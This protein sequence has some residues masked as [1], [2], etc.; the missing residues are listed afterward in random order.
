[1][2]KAC[3]EG[4]HEVGLLATPSILQ[5]RKQGQSGRKAHTGISGS[6]PYAKTNTC[7]TLGKQAL[8]NHSARNR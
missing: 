5:L 1:M 4:V 2:Q 7:F 6:Y 3:S 8:I